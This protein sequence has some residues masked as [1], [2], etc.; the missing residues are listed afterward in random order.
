MSLDFAHHLRAESARF[1]DAIGQTA[2]TDRV[3][4]CPDWD[5]DD[6]LWH[7]GGDVQWFWASVIAEDLRDTQQIIDLVDIERP[8]DREGLLALF[9]R[10][11]ARLHHLVAETDP[12][13]P[14]W[15]WVADTSLHQVEYLGRRQAHEA[16]I[17]RVDAELT[18]GLPISPIDPEFA[19]DGV[20][21][22]LRIIHGNHPAWGEFTPDG[23]TARM[24]ATDTDLSWVLDLGRFVGT[25]RDG[26]E[27]DI[28]S[29]RARSDD[30][31]EA[32]AGEMSADAMDLDLYLWGRPAPHF[33]VLEGD[34]AALDHVVAV[35]N[36][37]VA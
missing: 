1:L 23:R 21:E 4:T 27:V 11:S 19:S 7:L 31:G 20:D 16:L 35:V 30:Q 6:L 37:G 2:P 24:R 32:V 26:E 3:P 9:A 28:A 17:H 15:M 36:D 33:P 29:W 25:D 12:S 8:A 10:E 18:A 34:S 14:R 5:A 13:E 22:A